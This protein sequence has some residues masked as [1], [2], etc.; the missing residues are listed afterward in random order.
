MRHPTRLVNEDPQQAALAAAT[1]LHFH[2]FQS[3]G[4][5][6]TFGDLL[7]PLDLKC[8]SINYLAKS[9]A[10]PIGHQLKSGL[11]PTGV[12]R[13]KSWYYTTA[14]ATNIRPGWAKDKPPHC[15]KWGAYSF[16]L[17][18]FDKTL[19]TEDTE[20]HSELVRYASIERSHE[21]SSVVPNH[22]AD[23]IVVSG[24]GVEVHLDKNSLLLDFLVGGGVECLVNL[25]T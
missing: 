5:G 6:N 14:P 22:K 11:A 21:A 12:F 3:A 4:G 25:L 7:H 24:L 10:V 2:Q 13:Q 18:G 23:L 19:T 15:R 9:G 17:P 8:H 1:K 20:V 16:S